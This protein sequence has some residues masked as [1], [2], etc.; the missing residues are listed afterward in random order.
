[1]KWHCVYNLHEV[2]QTPSFLF[3]FNKFDYKNQ[4]A[5][6]YKKNIAMCCYFYKVEQSDVSLFELTEILYATKLFSTCNMDTYH[7]KD[8]DKCPCQGRQRG[9]RDLDLLVCVHDELRSRAQC[10]S[11]CTK[12]LSRNRR[13]K[14]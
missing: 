14:Y 3:Y 5:K 9:L 6:N 4:T 13:P 2:A 10:Q 8:V 7:P 12:L 11:C 1:M